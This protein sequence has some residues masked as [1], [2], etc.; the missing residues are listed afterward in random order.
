MNNICDQ[1]YCIHFLPYKNRLEPLKKE[2]ERCDIKVKFVY[3][4]DLGK[5][6]VQQAAEGHLQC[7]NDAIGN[8]YKKIIIMED[9][10]RFLKDIEKFNE[11][12][13]NIP[14]NAD[15]VLFDYIIANLNK[16]K[17]KMSKMK[18]KNNY[19]FPIG[20]E[21]FWN[22]SCYLLSDKA[23]N[24]ILVNQKK[25]MLPPDHYTTY[26]A[27]SVDKSTD[28]KYK[29][30]CPVECLCIQKV[31]DNNLRKKVHGVDNSYARYTKQG[32]DIRN[33]NIN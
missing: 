16:A 18:D 3:T 10:I 29:R 19:Y 33:Y 32:T 4:N 5:N 17:E 11:Y 9:D 12:C 2:F 30:Y 1:I 8:G 22:A 23:M 27:F 28:I 14:E 24:H 15:I 13:K 21:A 31:F 7:I 25:K 20:T 26:R 6:P